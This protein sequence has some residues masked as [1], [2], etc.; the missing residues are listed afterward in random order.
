MPDPIE[1]PS[2]P[3]VLQSI[4]QPEAL[5]RPRSKSDEVTTLLA[6]GL[7]GAY[8]LQQ[9]FYTKV[10]GATQLVDALIQA[11]K[12]SLSLHHKLLHATVAFAA[13]PGPVTNVDAPQG[14]ADSEPGEGSDAGQGGPSK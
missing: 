14:G 4:A 6:A 2:G 13:R 8:Q 12:V 7:V 10:P 3:E 9:R 5:P 1:E 11:T